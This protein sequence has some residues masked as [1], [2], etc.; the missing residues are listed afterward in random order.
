LLYLHGYFIYLIFSKVIKMSV[1][2]RILN[3]SGVG[4]ISSCNIIDLARRHS[5]YGGNRRNLSGA[6]NQEPPRPF[7]GV[8]PSFFTSDGSGINRLGTL[9][10]PSPAPAA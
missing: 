6:N 4:R 2:G 5:I 9:P 7:V 1:Y 10:P 8:E 3:M